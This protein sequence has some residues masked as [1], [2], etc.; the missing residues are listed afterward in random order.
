MVLDC[1]GHNLGT[2]EDTQGTRPPVKQTSA[3]AH[4]HPLLPNQKFFHRPLI[5]DHGVRVTT[6]DVRAQNQQILSL[7]TVTDFDTQASWNSL[8]RRVSPR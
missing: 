2:I 8:S 1:R 3:S 4:V 6:Q 5:N 7:L